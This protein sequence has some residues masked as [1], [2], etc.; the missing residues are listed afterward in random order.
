MV[1]LT[2]TKQVLASDDKK[3][4]TVVLT[5]IAN[6]EATKDMGFYK[7]RNRLSDIFGALNTRYSLDVVAQLYC[8]VADNTANFPA[9][10]I[11]DNILKISKNEELQNLLRS[12]DTDSILKSLYLYRYL[13]KTEKLNNTM[14]APNFSPHYETDMHK[15][16]MQDIGNAG[17]TGKLLDMAINTQKVDKQ[18]QQYVVTLMLERGN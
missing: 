11:R 7:L 5:W 17:A 14:K 15:I 2:T 8:D 16:F 4:E 12:A 6:K 9:Q 13:L 18:R 1:N 10:Q 3:Y